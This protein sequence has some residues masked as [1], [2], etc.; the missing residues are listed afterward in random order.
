MH[1]STY[2]CRYDEE[3]GELM[4]SDRADTHGVQDL[5]QR[6]FGPSCWPAPLCSRRSRYRND[7]SS[8]DRCNP[9]GTW[10]KRYSCGT[11]TAAPAGW[12][13]WRRG[14]CTCA[15]TNG[16]ETVAPRRTTCRLR[17][18]RF[19]WGIPAA[20]KTTFIWFFSLPLSLSRLFNHPHSL[21]RVTLESRARV[22]SYPSYFF[23]FFLPRCSFILVAIVPFAVFFLS[24]GVRYRFA[25]DDPRMKRNLS[26]WIIFS[27][28]S[29]IHNALYI[30]DSLTVLFTAQSRGSFLF[31]W[32]GVADGQRT[33][34]KGATRDKRCG[35]EFQFTARNC[36]RRKCGST[37]PGVKSKRRATVQEIRRVNQIRDAHGEGLL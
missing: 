32:R 10:S 13:G 27:C 29:K 19:E 30:L 6:F 24:Y 18:R 9:Y 12:P 7:A 31:L 33:D 26:D 1:V 28:G 15:C 11:W 25:I 37:N 17:N 21:R 22:Q 5:R 8:G 36:T 4:R 14:V 2:V 34:R 20:C 23:F 35:N 3:R 16:F